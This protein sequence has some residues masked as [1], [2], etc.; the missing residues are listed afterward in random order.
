M[1]GKRVGFFISLIGG[2]IV[3]LYLIGANYTRFVGDDFR[4]AWAMY[5]EPPPSL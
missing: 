4:S 5:A 3:E 1:L 2:N